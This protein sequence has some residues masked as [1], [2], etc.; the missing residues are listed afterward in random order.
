MQPVR[1]SP[2]QF[3]VM[4]E[5]PHLFFQLTIHRLLGRFIRA[6]PALRKLPTVVPGATSPEHVVQLI[7]EDDADIG[8]I[9]FLIQHKKTVASIEIECIF[10]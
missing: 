9:A 5:Q 1:G 3:H 10:P 7:A 2:D 8:P 4:L 6:H